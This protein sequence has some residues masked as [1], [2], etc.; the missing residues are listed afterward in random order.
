MSFCELV[1]WLSRIKLVLVMYVQSD[2]I[3]CHPEY[4]V[5]ARRRMIEKYPYV[6]KRNTEAYIDLLSMIVRNSEL[7]GTPDKNA[8]EELQHAIQEF[9]N[10][11][12]SRVNKLRSL[13][14][15]GIHFLEVHL[16]EK[17]ME[18]LRRW[19][20]PVKRMIFRLPKVT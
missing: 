3:S 6:M 19:Y 15:R 4:S 9:K 18:T 12:K 5:T 2:S 10:T 8:E 7:L 20:Q 14:F 11:Q 16:P 13:Y 1:V 17:E